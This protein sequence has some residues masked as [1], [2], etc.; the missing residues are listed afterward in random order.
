MRR[1]ALHLTAA[2][3]S[4]THGSYD[5]NLRNVLLHHFLDREHANM[6]SFTSTPS[7]APNPTSNRESSMKLEL[8]A[9]LLGIPAAAVA[10]VTIWNLLFLWYQEIKGATL[11][12]PTPIL[13]GTIT[14]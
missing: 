3:I 5:Q 2:F 1:N 14:N 9:F 4:W 12:S 11:P 10:L 13:F 8:L 6:P 7:L